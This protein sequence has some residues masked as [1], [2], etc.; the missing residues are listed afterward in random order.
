M[1]AKSLKLSYNFFTVVIQVKCRD[2]SESKS[3]AVSCRGS[4]ELH[5]ER[6]GVSMRVSIGTG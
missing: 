4:I 5:R 3:M 2:V 1:S 6:C